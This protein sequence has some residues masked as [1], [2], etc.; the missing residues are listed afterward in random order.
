MLHGRD[1][2]GIFKGPLKLPIG[3]TDPFCIRHKT[4]TFNYQ[5]PSPVLTRRA[6]VEGASVLDNR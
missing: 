3:M 1:T 6:I 2:A 4:K 5:R